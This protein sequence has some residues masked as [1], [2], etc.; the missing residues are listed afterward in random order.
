[1]KKVI[2]FTISIILVLS[3][4]LLIIFKIGL[5]KEGSN[6]IFKN[7]IREVKYD[8]PE[9]NK[10]HT[11]IKG[12]SKSENINNIKQEILAYYYYDEIDNSEYEIDS[13]TGE[14][15]VKAE[16]KAYYLIR[17]LY[18]NGNKVGET[19]KIDYSNEKDMINQSNNDF[20]SIK[21]NKIIDIDSDKEY[22]ILTLTDNIMNTGLTYVKTS[23]VYIIN[24]DYEIIQELANGNSTGYINIPIYKDELGDRNYLN[25]INTFNK[26]FNTEFDYLL[27]SENGYVDILKKKIYYIDVNASKCEIDEHE[28]KISNGEIKDSYSKTYPDVSKYVTGDGYC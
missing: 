21:T 25:G 7:Q 14:E 3:I 1:M 6:I 28:I 5:F 15:T 11:F 13:E 8:K 12:Y 17:E 24:E 16:S 27:Y 19:S 22:L 4:V 9:I 2:A 10:D 23:A 20:D 26:M 18:I